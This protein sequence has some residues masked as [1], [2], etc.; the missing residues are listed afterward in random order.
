MTWNSWCP[1]FV[2]KAVLARSAGGNYY[3]PI[4]RRKVQCTEILCA[5]EPIESLVDT[6]Y[7]VGIFHGQ[8]IDATKIHTE[9]K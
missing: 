6:W 8:L 4:A 9:A 1:P 3:L 2:E 5:V 7:R